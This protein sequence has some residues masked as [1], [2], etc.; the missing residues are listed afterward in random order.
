MSKDFTVDNKKKTG[1]CEYVYDFYMFMNMFMNL[2]IIH[3]LSVLISVVEI[4]ILLIIH[5]HKVKKYL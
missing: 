4:V 3:L 1:L 2:F 5:I